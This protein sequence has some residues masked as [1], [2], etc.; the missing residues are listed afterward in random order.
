MKKITKARKMGVYLFPYREYDD[1]GRL[2][3]REGSLGSFTV[4]IYDDNDN[5]IYKQMS[6]STGSHK[7][8][9]RKFDKRG[10]KLYV[11][12]KDIFN[13]FS[14]ARCKYDDDNEELEFEDSKGNWWH[15]DYFNINFKD[16]F[17]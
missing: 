3:Y 4:W 8:I 14:W 15:R 9:F 17:V 13:N 12:T 10:N 16:L 5:V 6:S 7:W 11:R 2:V 1:K